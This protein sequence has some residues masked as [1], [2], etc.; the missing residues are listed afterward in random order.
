MWPFDAQP[1]IANYFS[2]SAPEAVLPKHPY[3][4]LGVEVAGYLANEWSV[5]TLLTIF[6]TG[7]AAIFSC[8]YLIV[9]KIRPKLPTS[10]LLTILWF[11]LCGFI[12]TF[13]EG[14]YAYNFRSMGPKQDLFG[15]LWKEYAMSDSR[16]L[17]RDA[18]T[19][20]M[21]T[22][23]AVAWG[24]LSFTVAGLIA[25]DSS[26]R[27]PL[28][29]VLSLGQLYGDVL[30]YSTSMFD[31]FLLGKTYWRP[32]PYYFWCYYFT[33]NTFWIVIPFSKFIF[34]KHF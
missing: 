15:Q 24:P 25:T 6:A 9:T 7:C 23:T 19:L 14:Y 26:W 16:Y 22:I 28:Q 2:H 21:E 3:Y 17:T 4:P 8:T 32:E 34:S 10:E 12:H 33:M 11:V 20:C 30:Y 27:H 5:L 18:F 31:F 13:F 29:I 1:T